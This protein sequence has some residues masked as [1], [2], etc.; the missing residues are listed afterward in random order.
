MLN[1]DMLRTQRRVEL[2][3]NSGVG[4]WHF[5]K[6]NL[7]FHPLLWLQAGKERQPAGSEPEFVV[8]RDSC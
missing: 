7:A 1:G 8:L 6:R 5:E 3:A 2:F 4:S